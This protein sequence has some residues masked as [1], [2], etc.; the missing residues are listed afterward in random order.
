MKK[1]LTEL[2]FILDRSGSMYSMTEDT[3]G[4]FNSMIAK[5]KEEDG[6]CIV[7]TVLF[8]DS[9]KVIHDRVPLREVKEMTERDYSA[10]GSTAQI[11][12]LGSAIKHIRN[13]HRYIREEDVPEHTMFIITTDGYENASHKYS[14][15]DVKRMVRAQEENGWE[16]VFL[17]ANID[18]VETAKHYGIRPER[19]ANYHNDSRGLGVVYEKVSDMACSMRTS[20]ALKECIF[21]ELR[22]DY[23]SRK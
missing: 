20:G 22:E 14:S 2:V 12:A 15:N 3:I 16:F 13:V 8:N 10:S 6:E 1:D 7:S 11:D 5:Q 4:G 18:A 19:T 23:E 9:S 21:D 17:A